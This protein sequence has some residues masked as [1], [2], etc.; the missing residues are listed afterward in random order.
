MGS[1]E[2]RLVISRSEFEAIPPDEE[3]PIEPL[4]NALIGDSPN[5]TQQ[6]FEEAFSDLT[7]GQQLLMRLGAFD[8]NVLNGGLTQ[9]FWNKPDAI[10]AVRDDI[11]TLGETEL[12]QNYEWA[13]QSLIGSRERWIELK[14]EWDRGKQSPNFETFRESYELLKLNWFDHAYFDY[15]ETPG[16]PLHRGLGHSLMTKLAE[17]V[18]QRPSEFIAEPLVD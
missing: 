6:H 3:Y 2:T 14:Q 7:Q 16:G 13:V 11:D 9:F 8:S 10:F 17:F 18:R 12:L 15:R 4:Y 5:V 1:A